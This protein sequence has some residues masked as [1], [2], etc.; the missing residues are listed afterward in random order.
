MES[1][2]VTL[3]VVEGASFIASLLYFSFRAGRLLERVE[4]IDRRTLAL[5]RLRDRTIRCTDE[6]V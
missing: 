3:L 4:S 6:E 2:I 5:E 1:W